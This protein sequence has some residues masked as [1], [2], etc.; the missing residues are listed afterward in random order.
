MKKEE[1]YSLYLQN[2]EEIEAE[3]I[4][5]LIPCWIPKGGITLLVGDG[6]I[7]KT[8]LWTCL[9]SDLSRGMPT[10]LHPLSAS[11][12]GCIGTYYPSKDR[13][14]GRFIPN[15]NN[16]VC[17]YFSKED[18][19]A[20][21]LKENFKRY[22]ANTLNIRT[23]DIESLTGFTYASE[24]L[25]KMI[26]DQRPGIVVFDPIQAFFPKGSSMTSRQQTRK[27]LDR[28]VQL[29]QEYNTAFLL[30]CHTNK[31]GTD[32]W[33]QR[34]SGSADLPDIARSVIF[35]SYTEIDANHRIRFISNEKNSYAPLQQTLLYSFDERGLIRS[36][37][38]TPR[39]FADFVRDEPYGEK[40]EKKKSQKELCKEEILRILQEKGEMKVSELDELMKA[41]EFGTK[42]CNTAKTELV[43]SGEIERDRTKNEW[44]VRL[45]E[46]EENAEEHMNTDEFP[47][48]DNE[49]ETTAMLMLV[50]EKD[51]DS[52]PAEIHEEY[53]TAEDNPR[54]SGANDGN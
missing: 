13:K 18:S 22:E 23:I 10:I 30:V 47:E 16:M 53:G 15:S 4:E 42:T 3:D 44:T 14:T 9:I 29:G 54:S 19:T 31:K 25:E 17:L 36:G 43:N 46:R 33:R 24:A 26:D 45:K 50:K 35:T 1:D 32:D 48:P 6:G 27:V 38:T 37:W 21:R 5:W 7:G 41:A 34:V 52:A 39:R 12:H 20:K 49:K 40:Q 8:N 51:E 2:V 28:L 11:D